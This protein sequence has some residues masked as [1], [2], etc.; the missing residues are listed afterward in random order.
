M[1]RDQFAGQWKILKGHIKTKWG[2]LTDDE[3]TQVNGKFEQL[4]GLLQKKYGLAKE[5]ASQEIDT[6][7]QT[8]GSTKDT[9]S[10]QGQFSKGQTDRTNTSQGQQPQRMFADQDPSSRTTRGT[11]SGSKGGYGQENQS[12]RSDQGKKGQQDFGKTRQNN[13]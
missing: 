6:W 8:V 7:L 2:K 9:G 12:Q 10:T 3:I 5:K 11:Q 1:N 4:A 13:R